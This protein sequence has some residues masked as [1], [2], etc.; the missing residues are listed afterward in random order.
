M[1]PGPSLSHTKS[2]QLRGLAQFGEKRAKFYED[3]PTFAEI[4]HPKVVYSSWFG[5]VAPK[6]IPDPIVEKL[7]NLVKQVTNDPAFIKI[8]ENAGEEV[9]YV[10]AE[11][12]KKA[13]HKE[14]DKLYKLLEKLEKGKK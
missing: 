8:I 11:T 14:Y 1:F 10:D 3:I 12:T 5:L 7:R 4:G 9:E 2:K 13:W 6:G